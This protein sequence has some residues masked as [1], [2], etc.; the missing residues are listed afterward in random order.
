MRLTE[1]SV[2]PGWWRRAFCTCAW[3]EAQ[4]MPETESLARAVGAA[5]AIGSP[6]PPSVKGVKVRWF[7]RCVSMADS[8]PPPARPCRPAGKR[9]FH[10]ERPA[11][12][13]HPAGEFV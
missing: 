9:S 10:N 13:R 5:G 2:T 8:L 6:P 12:H 3:Q 11:E 7:S 1:A 4:D